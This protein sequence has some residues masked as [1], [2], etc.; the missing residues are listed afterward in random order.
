M[1]KY[2]HYLFSTVT[3]VRTKL[4]PYLFVLHLGTRSLVPEGRSWKTMRKG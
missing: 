4:F 3:A 2:D 1:C